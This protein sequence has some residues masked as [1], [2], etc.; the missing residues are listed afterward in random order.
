M[1]LGNLPASL[2]KV[3]PGLI[4]A[5]VNYRISEWKDMVAHIEN[6]LKSAGIDYALQAHSGSGILYLNL[7]LNQIDSGLET[8][9]VEF[10]SGLLARS[11]RAGGNTIVQIAPPDL[12]PKL[13]IWGETGSDFVAMQFLK[14]NMDPHGVLNPGRFVGGL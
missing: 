11:R 9:A 8:K 14:K 10:M 12:K 5:K 7:L 6:A 4:R 3:H 1:T 2:D 13:K